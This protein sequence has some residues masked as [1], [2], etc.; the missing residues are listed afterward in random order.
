MVQSKKVAPFYKR[1]KLRLTGEVRIH[2]K[3]ALRDSVPLG[4]LQGLV[5]ANSAAA[6]FSRKARA[7]PWTCPQCR[8][9]LWR[10]ATG[11][12]M[13]SVSRAEL[14]K[15]TQD[16]GPASLTRHLACADSTPRAPGAP[17]AQ[18]PRPHK[19]SWVAKLIHEPK[20]WNKN[21]PCS[22]AWKLKVQDNLFL[23]DLKANKLSFTTWLITINRK[24]RVLSPPWALS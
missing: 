22:G 23:I 21:I 7:P 16:E 15:P 20:P 11:L 19:R 24:E 6:V 3:T 5:K 17:S 12:L 10:Q 13:H 8:P 9:H 1:G 14:Q 2:S 4:T 18:W